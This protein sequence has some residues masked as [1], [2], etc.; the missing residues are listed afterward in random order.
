MAVVKD[1]RIAARLPEDQAALIRTAAEA[2]GTTVTAFMVN[3]AVTRAQDVLADQ[4][5]F[6]LDDAT[7]AS[8]QATLDRPVSP[9]PRLA[10]LFTEEPVF[11]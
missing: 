8:F 3:A 1:S 2:E 10:A 9:K 6:L 4:R 5:V 11:E 7:W